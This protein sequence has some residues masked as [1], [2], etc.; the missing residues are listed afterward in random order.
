M[1]RRYDA[2]FAK[3]RRAASAIARHV[4]GDCGV[5]IPQARLDELYEVV[6]SC[7]GVD[8]VDAEAIAR[9]CQLDPYVEDEGSR[10]HG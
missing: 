2:R 7:L 10:T 4:R 5:R 9:A 3:A 1:G 8:E 6:R